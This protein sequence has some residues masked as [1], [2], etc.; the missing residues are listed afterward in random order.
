MGRV[1]EFETFP[2]STLVDRDDYNYVN[3][4]VAVPITRGDDQA[5]SGK[6]RRKDI[7]GVLLYT[8]GRS[9][10]GY[11]FR[12]WHLVFLFLFWFLT[13]AE[14]TWMGSG[15]RASADGYFE[16]SSLLQDMAGRA[17]IYPTDEGNV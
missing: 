2:R 9:R 13:F 7:L 11:L 6:G 3:R 12:Y 10:V 4:R 1:R 16:G 14:G 17:G 8:F 5:R 15:K